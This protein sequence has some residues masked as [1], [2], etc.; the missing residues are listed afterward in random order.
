L[1]GLRNLKVL[2]LDLATCCRLRNMEGISPAVIELSMAS[3]PNLVSLAGIQGCISMEK[4]ALKD[5][6]VSL[7]AASTGLKQTST[8]AV[9]CMSYTHFGGLSTSRSL[10]ALSLGF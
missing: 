5:C 10:Q 1:A 8:L 6:G 3:A 9:A 2:G 4:L 7:F